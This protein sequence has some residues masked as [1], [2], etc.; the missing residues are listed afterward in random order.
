V[1]VAAIK[2]ARA[3]SV[4]AF[5]KILLIFTSRL[6]RDSGSYEAEI[7]PALTLQG[8][9]IARFIRTANIFCIA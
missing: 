1:A 5:Q 9:F 2:T 4:V 6:S 7:R 3:A 8:K